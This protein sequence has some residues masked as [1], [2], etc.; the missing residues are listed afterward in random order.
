MG[1]ETAG[2]P[3]FRFQ[4]GHLAVYTLLGVIQLGVTAIQGAE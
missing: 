1:S 2:H 4:R 3:G